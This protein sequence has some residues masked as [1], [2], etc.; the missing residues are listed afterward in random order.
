[1]FLQ[2]G[3][4]LGYQYVIIE[5]SP[6]QNEVLKTKHL[7]SIEWAKCG[8]GDKLPSHLVTWQSVQ[9]KKIILY[10]QDDNGRL[11]TRFGQISPIRKHIHQVGMAYIWNGFRTDK[12]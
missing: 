8:N 5:N 9:I 2:V 4:K 3:R 7:S 1:M 10:C 12:L 11:K 6:L